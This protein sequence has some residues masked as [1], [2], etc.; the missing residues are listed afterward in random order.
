M[1][2]GVGSHSLLQGSSRP[3]DRTCV[4][5]GSCIVG[6]LLTSEPPGKPYP[7]VLHKKIPEQ[8]GVTQEKLLNV[9][10]T[11]TF[12]IIFVKFLCVCVYV[13]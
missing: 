4:F 11:A 12:H 6:T 1:N 13:L 7:W 3:R 8:G 5:C 9:P 2:T 10:L